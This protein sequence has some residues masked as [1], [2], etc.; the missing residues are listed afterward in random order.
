MKK[1]KYILMFVLVFISYDCLAY[2]ENGERYC[3]AQNMYFEA[4][5]ESTAGQLAVGLVTL[6]RVKMWQYPNNV[7]DVIQQ[8]PTYI[9]W[10]GNVLPV[11]DKCQFSW[12]C[13]GQSDWPED[14]KTFEK[15]LE[16]AS[17]LMD[18]EVF[19]FTEGSNHYHNN[20][21]QPFWAEHLE[22]TVTIDNH[23]FYK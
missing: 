10:K 15:M 22:Q 23:I 7:C 12:Y 13:D 2:D 5:G 16:L 18:T 14:S 17:L 19:D 8:G 1:F 20:T 4:G 6:N 3:L 9:N 11:R 21:V